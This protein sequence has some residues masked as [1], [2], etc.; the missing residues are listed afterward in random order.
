M[1]GPIRMAQLI[2]IVFFAVGI[3]G[4]VYVHMKGTKVEEFQVE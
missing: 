4:M 1:F 2:S 3:V